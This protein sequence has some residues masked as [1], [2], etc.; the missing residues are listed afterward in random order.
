MAD[1]PSDEQGLA[2]HQDRFQPFQHRSQPGRR[3]PVGRLSCG[4]LRHREA[5]GERSVH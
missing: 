3:Q 4:W 2:Q 5:G 1:H